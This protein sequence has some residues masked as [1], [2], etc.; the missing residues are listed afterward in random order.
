MSS[1]TGKPFDT[2][3]FDNHVHASFA[4]ADALDSP[5]HLPALYSDVSGK[6][7]KTWYRLHRLL[8]MS[9]P[10][11]P[12]AVS[13][14]QTQQIRQHWAKTRYWWKCSCPK[15]WQRPEPSLKSAVTQ[16][17]AHLSL[18]RLLLPAAPPHSAARFAWH[19]RLRLASSPTPIQLTS[20]TL[21]S[22]SALMLRKRLSTRGGVELAR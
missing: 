11:L 4:T 14:I 10:Q 19:V 5:I 1:A 21:G 2:E 9:S 12:P 13:W 22:G 6:T 20:V 7:Q 8:P 15:K 3:S 18:D 16:C 17:L